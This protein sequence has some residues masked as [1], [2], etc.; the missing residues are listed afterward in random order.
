MTAKA[1]EASS[2][3]LVTSIT[4]AIISTTTPDHVG[5]ASRIVGGRRCLASPIAMSCAVARM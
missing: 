1:I 4:V 5:Y 3:T 2:D